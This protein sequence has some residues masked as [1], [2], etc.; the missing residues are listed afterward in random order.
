M[1]KLF[2]IQPED[3][4]KQLSIKVENPERV[5]NALFAYLNY[6]SSGESIETSIFKLSK[7]DPNTLYIESTVDRDDVTNILYKVSTKLPI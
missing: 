1:S 7:I 4:L 6:L 3:F 5:I 2:T